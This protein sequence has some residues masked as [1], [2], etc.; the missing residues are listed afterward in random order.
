MSIN[1]E[2]FKQLMAQQTMIEPTQPTIKTNALDHEREV[3][4]GVSAQTA[5]QGR[6]LA[7]HARESVRDPYA[8]RS[9]M[10]YDMSVF[11][12]INSVDYPQD[13]GPISMPPPK[14]AQNMSAQYDLPQVESLS[15]R[16]AKQSS[17]NFPTLDAISQA[18]AQE[19]S[20]M[21]WLGSFIGSN[22]P[23]SEAEQISQE[24]WG[25]VP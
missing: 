21:E 22:E 24:A 15:Y 23:M 5:Y 3:L 12:D 4:P 25:E 14:A 1:Q 18:P 10:N 2:A 8:G 7:D 6:V 11:D 19:Q 9:V 13:A 20:L 16:P 17:T